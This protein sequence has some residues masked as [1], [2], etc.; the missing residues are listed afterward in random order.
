MCRSVKTAL[1]D[2][3]LI[4]FDGKKRIERILFFHLSSSSFQDHLL[5]THMH[6]NAN[7]IVK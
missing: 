2:P 1:N 6:L 5:V 7:L 3:S 4:L